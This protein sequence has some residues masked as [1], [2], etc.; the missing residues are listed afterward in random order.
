MTNRIF[1]I[2]EESQKEK[3]VVETPIEFEDIRVAPATPNAFIFD[4]EEKIEEPVVEE[5]VEEPV[6]EE[7]IKIEEPVIEEPVEEIVEESVIQQPHREPVIPTGKVE[8]N[9]LPEIK[10]REQASK[11]PQERI[12]SNKLKEGD[13][14]DIFK[15][16]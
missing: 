15:R 9:D 12:G 4:K 7:P 2:E 3:P 1:E 14:K 6:I 16:F 11:T 8:L 5:V 10:N 13:N